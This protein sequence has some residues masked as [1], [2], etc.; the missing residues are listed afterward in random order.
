MY[1]LPD[2]GLRVSVR[3]PTGADEL[4]VLE[5]TL[6][7]PG[8]VAALLERLCRPLDPPPVDLAPAGWTWLSVTDAA[9]LMLFVRRVMAGE[10]IRSDVTCPV[11]SC[12]QK[13]EM[14]FAIGE[15]VDSHAPVL[16]R[17]VKSVDP[18]EA[19]PGEAVEAGEL[20]AG[21][22]FALEGSAVR[23]R[24]PTLGDAVAVADVGAGAAE[25]LVRR[26]V[27]PREVDSRARRR[28]ERAMAAMAPTL[29]G[30]L[31]G[32]CPSCGTAVRVFFDPTAFCLR[33]LRD[34]APFV[35][36]DVDLLARRYHWD[37]ETILALPV[38]RRARYVDLAR[39]GV[40]HWPE[41]GD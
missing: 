17:S 28:V 20:L 16:P 9:A 30:E 25:E 29:S 11:K 15:Y 13:V 35:Y 3:E 14:S 37:E 24:R 18:G 26:C 4:L 6:P 27:R 39:R 12:G 33:E 22:W 21:E 8:L 36:E 1:R 10:V 40:S 41:I 2:S 7:A 5:A 31:G 34:R 23:F 38:S 32:T 19:F